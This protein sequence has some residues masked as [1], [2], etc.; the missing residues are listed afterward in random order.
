[1]GSDVPCNYIPRV[2]ERGQTEVWSILDK[3]YGDS[4]IGQEERVLHDPAEYEA[5]RL[6]VEVWFMGN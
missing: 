5:D 2:E 1:M 4:R 6:E 3:S